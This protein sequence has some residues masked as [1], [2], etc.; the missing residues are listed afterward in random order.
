MSLVNNN[1]SILVHETCDK[2]AILMWNVNKGTGCGIYG[3]CL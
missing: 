1:A 2:C 3:N